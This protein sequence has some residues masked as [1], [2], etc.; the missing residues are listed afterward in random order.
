MPTLSVSTMSSPGVASRDAS[1]WVLAEGEAGFMEFARA[2]EGW[3]LMKSGH[4]EKPDLVL[5]RTG[6]I[7]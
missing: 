7:D 6:D 3:R 4:N 5:T 1:L 2:D